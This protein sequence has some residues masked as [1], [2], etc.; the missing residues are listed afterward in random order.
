MQINNKNV[1]RMNFCNNNHTD[2][3]SLVLQLTWITHTHTHTSSVCLSASSPCV[4][5]DLTFN[6][7][8]FNELSQVDD[9]SSG[10]TGLYNFL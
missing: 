5:A 10:K 9:G 7:L 3:F 8:L 6:E 2:V 4:P 1:S